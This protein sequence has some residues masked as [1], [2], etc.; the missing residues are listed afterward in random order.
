MDNQAKARSAED[1]I[2]ATLMIALMFLTLGNVISRYFL[3]FS[4]SLT[5]EI[6]IVLFFVMT[7]LGTAIAFR[8]GS[9]LRIEVLLHIL[10]ARQQRFWSILSDLSVILLFG[11]LAWYGALATY[12]EWFYG[13]K[14]SALGVPQWIYTVWLPICSAVVV[15]RAM[16]KLSATL[17][18]GE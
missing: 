3:K 8:R 12:D 4:I 13:A 2:C 16:G 11:M 18:D 5:E 17:S 9:H 15:L 14:S 10:S 1:Y 6:S 7:L